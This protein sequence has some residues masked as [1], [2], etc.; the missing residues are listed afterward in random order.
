MHGYKPT[1]DA[2][3]ITGEGRAEFLRAWGAG[4]EQEGARGA[5]G[6][7]ALNMCAETTNLIKGT[8]LTVA[9][10]MHQFIMANRFTWPHLTKS[11]KPDYF[12]NNKVSTPPRVNR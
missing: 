5:A 1:P 6:G 7:G 9:E 8:N 12:L 4:F 10:G 3:R 2:C 11:L